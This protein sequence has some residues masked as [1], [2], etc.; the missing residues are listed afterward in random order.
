MTTSP[1]SGRAAFG[2]VGLAV[3]G[4]NL[5]LNVADR[6]FATAVW[7]REPELVPPFVAEAKGKPIVGT[8]E[9]R[10][11]VAALARPRK[12][13]LMIRAGAPVDEMIERLVPLLEAGDILIDGGNSRFQDTQRR[14][15]AVRAKGLHFVGLG[16]SGGEEGARHGPAL[17][18]GGT[19]EAYAALRPILEA[20]A[21][22]SD[23]GAC[24]SHLGPD[25]AGHFVKM[26]HNGIEYADMQLLAEAYDLLQ[27]GL[28]R[29]AGDLARIF[30]AWNSGPLG[31][32][33][34]EVTAK[35]FGVV[36]PET[37]RPLVDLVLDKAG[38]KGTG[39]WTAEVALELGVPVPSIAA[40]IDARV[41]SSRK[42]ARVHAS[43]L[44]AGPPA[45]RLDGALD[46]FTQGIH[47]ALL[48]A[49]ICAYAQGLDL[50]RSASER[51]GWKIDLRETARIWKAGCI[52][53]ARLLDTIM[54]AY[55]QDPALPNLL[56]APHFAATVSSLQLGWRRVVGV[57]A[58]FGIPTPAL[59]S[60]LHYFDALR[61]ERLPQNLTQAQRDAFG[62]HTYERVDHPERGPVHSQWL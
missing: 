3:M 36:D 21:A 61:T 14:E 26:V 5:A 32:F 43:K 25:G 7:N 28:G 18:P 55:G 41:L 60:S 11:F 53:R 52:I 47:D 20:I 31:S 8:V 23:S 33:L 46:T 49:K 4:R 39:Q 1:S 15:A 37:G 22:K 19:P 50:I 16:V 12:I 48:C 54:Q 9:L 42:S 57:A 59:S 45:I 51:F 24:V 38:Q 2:V 10:D 62:A 34:V 35:V 40:A 56:L 27:R 30:G 17:M 58:S 6:G 13:L 29:S 44:L